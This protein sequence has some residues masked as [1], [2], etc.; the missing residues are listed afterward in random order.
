MPVFTGM[1][2]WADAGFHNLN[3]LKVTIGSSTTRHDGCG[4]MPVGMKFGAG[5]GILPALFLRFKIKI[6]LDVSVEGKSYSAMF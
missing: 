6:P 2:S 3:N 4:W 5:A 1:T